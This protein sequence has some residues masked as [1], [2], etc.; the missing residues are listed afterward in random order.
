LF[1]KQLIRGINLHPDSFD[2]DIVQALQSSFIKLVK[3][4]DH[5]EQENITE[6]NAV[7]LIFVYYFFVF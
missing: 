3:N 5:Q 2:G 4:V 6:G 7:L 1:Y